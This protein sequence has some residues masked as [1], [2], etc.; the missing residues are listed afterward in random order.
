[1]PVTESWIPV[2]TTFDKQLVDRLLGEGRRFQ[3]GLSV[4]LTDTAPKPCA[5]SV[6]PADA[7]AVH[8][9]ALDASRI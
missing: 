4:V 6:V 2:D 5:M 9:R 1:M 8:A 3:K 7:T